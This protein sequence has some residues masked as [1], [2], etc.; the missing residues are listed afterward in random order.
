MLNAFLFSSL[1]IYFRFYATKSSRK[2]AKQPVMGRYL[3][4]TEL[5]THIA[6]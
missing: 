4:L 2:A 1:V 5:C 3:I 6:I